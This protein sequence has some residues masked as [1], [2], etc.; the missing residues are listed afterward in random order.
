LE[1]FDKFIEARK[2]LIAARF[3]G[4]LPGD[5][6]AEKVTDVGSVQK[7]GVQSEAG[8]HETEAELT[9]QTTVIANENL[10]VLR[11]IVLKIGAEGGSLT[12]LRER[13]VEQGWQFR[14]ELNET[15]L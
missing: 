11:E 12:V 1:N 7:G 2:E 14:I 13:T 4:M 15:T 6:S 10:K 8:A 5:L 9:I 3:S